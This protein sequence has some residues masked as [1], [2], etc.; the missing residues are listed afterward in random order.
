M[1]ST[2]SEVSSDG[3]TEQKL[4]LCRECRIRTLMNSE[5]SRTQTTKHAFHV[6]QY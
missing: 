5:Y 1:N 2:S 6:L 4:F 3:E